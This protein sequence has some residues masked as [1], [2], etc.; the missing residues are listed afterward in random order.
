MACRPFLFPPFRRWIDYTLTER[1]DWEAKGLS[2]CPGFF[3]SSFL[4][5]F[6]IFTGG[7][8]LSSFF[9]ASTVHETRIFHLFRGTMMKL[10]SVSSPGLSQDPPQLPHS[11]LPSPSFPHAIYVALPSPRFLPKHPNFPFIHS[12][13]TSPPRIHVLG[14]LLIRPTC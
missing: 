2:E 6:H 11:H 4:F 13:A 8:L 9:L 5:S 14:C 3:S 10:I 1:H 7:N 12:L